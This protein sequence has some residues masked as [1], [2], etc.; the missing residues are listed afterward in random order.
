MFYV[1]VTGAN[2]DVDF[3]L[4][5]LVSQNGSTVTAT[6]TSGDDTIV[7]DAGAAVTPLLA[8]NGV[9][10][11]FAPG[12]ATQFN[13]DGGAGSD[14]ITVFGTA[15][16][17]SA[18][19]RPGQ[20]SLT[21]GAVALNATGVEWTYSLGAGG[22]D[23]ATFFDSAGDDWLNS[24]SMNAVVYGAG[25]AN[26]AMGFATVNVYSTG[27]GFDRADIYDSTLDDVVIMRSDSTS[28][29]NANSYLYARGF[30]QVMA[31]AKYGGVDSAHMFDSAGNDTFMGRPTSSVMRG[32]A[33]YN[34]ADGFESVSAYATAGGSDASY[35]YGSAGNETVSVRGDQTEMAG[36]SFTLVSRGF[37]TTKVA[38]MGGNDSA[39]FFDVATADA[40]Y[41]VGNRA[42]LVRGGRSTRF[43][44]FSHVAAMLAGTTA[45]PLIDVGA[46]DYLFEVL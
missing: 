37:A 33:Y 13:F 6:G 21:S 32:A 1:R 15:G 9:S 42:Q 2:S 36:T 41:G 18:T 17:D 39:N 7:F 10:Y 45:T 35:V 30:D 20:L 31:V 29:R 28:L 34:Q 46:V 8:I 23:S 44:D 5:N 25:Y 38:G 12:S 4:L 26:R 27:G 16:A 14:V 40:I 3:K 22:A 43:E 19:F 11:G 24:E